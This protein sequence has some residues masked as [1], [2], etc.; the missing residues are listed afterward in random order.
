[1]SR[2]LPFWEGRF[3]WGESNE[4]TRY[5]KDEEEEEEED[6]NEEASIVTSRT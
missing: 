2:S 3:F 1:M 5:K 6:P 4:V